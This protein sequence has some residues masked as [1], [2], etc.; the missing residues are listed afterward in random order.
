M[1]NK[2]HYSPTDPEAR[3]S[4]K[5]GKARALNYLCSVAV[6]TAAGLISHIQA[7][8]ADRRDS[9]H[10]PDLVP[11]LQTRLVAN[12]LTLRDFVAD[13]GYSNGFN[14]A[15]LEQRSVTPWIPVFGAYKPAPE[16]FTYEAEVDA[17]RCPAGKLLPFR[18]YATSKDGNW[19]KNYR[20]AYQDCQQC[21]LKMSCTPAAPQQ[22]FVR[23]A[24]AAAYRRAWHRQHS[25]AGQQMR[26]VRQRT[27]EPV[28]GSLLHHYGLR[29]VGTKGRAAAHKAMLLSAIAYNLKKLLKYQSKPTAR[30]AIAL[31]PMQQGSYSSLFSAWLTTSN[32][33]Q[34]NSLTECLPI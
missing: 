13:T 17:F 29:R 25:R 10:V 31:Y 12:E 5:P 2:T 28:F 14:Y 19:A 32:S 30:V 11:R 3:I 24:F 21:P 7:D 20:A 8:F 15:F 1:S 18:N 6:D 27:V 34:V 33:L 26:R 9:T 22:K 4:V 16:G 23:S